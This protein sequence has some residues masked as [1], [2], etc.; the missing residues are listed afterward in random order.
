MEEIRGKWREIESGTHT[1][2]I[3]NGVYYEGSQREMKGNRVREMEGNRVWEMEENRVREMEGY[4]GKQ[5]QG[6]G[7]K[8]R[9]M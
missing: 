7:G 9:E 5:S 3:V 4:R 1:S 6:D 8:Q 2:L